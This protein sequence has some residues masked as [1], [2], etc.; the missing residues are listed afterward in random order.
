[1]AALRD[2]SPGPLGHVTLRG[3]RETVAILCIQALEN[4]GD[5]AGRTALTP[6]RKGGYHRR[7]NR[8]K[9]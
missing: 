1:M 8:D 3:D 9:P 5:N 6:A 4:R 2:R 7:S